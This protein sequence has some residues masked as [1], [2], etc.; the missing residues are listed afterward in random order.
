ML[1]SQRNFY[2]INNKFEVNK[3]TFLKEVSFAH[4]GSIYLKKIYFWNNKGIKV[5]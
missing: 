4:K 2:D 3:L 1:Y 5:S